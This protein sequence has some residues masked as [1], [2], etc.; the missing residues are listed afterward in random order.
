MLPFCIIKCKLSWH[1]SFYLKVVQSSLDWAFHFQVIICF[2]HLCWFTPMIIMSKRTVLSNL[3]LLPKSVVLLF[4]CVTLPRQGY[5]QVPWWIMRRKQFSSTNL[6]RA[7]GGRTPA[8]PPTIPIAPP[9]NQSTNL[10]SCNV[11]T[12][13]DSDLLSVLFL[14]WSLLWHLH[15]CVTIEYSQAVERGYNSQHFQCHPFWNT[16]YSLVL[17]SHPARN[18]LPSLR[19]IL[20]SA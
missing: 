12:C 5:W 6:L 11:K 2:R 18:F 14:S 15:P 1:N 9:S 20:A 10:K 16:I 4:R 19:V 8:T 3:Y 17:Q 13:S 7:V